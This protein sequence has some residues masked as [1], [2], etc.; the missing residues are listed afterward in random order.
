MSVFHPSDVLGQFASNVELVTNASTRSGGFTRSAYR[1]T[2]DKEPESGPDGRYFLDMVR[3]DPHLRRWG[4][5]SK[6]T[7]ST[8][9]V[10]LLY[11]RPGGGAGGGDRQSVMR[12]AADDCDKLADVCE[13]PANYGSSTSGIRIVTFQSAQ[14]V[15]QTSH[16]EIWEVLFACQWQSDL[17]TDTVAEMSQVRWIADGID[18]GTVQLISLSV[19]SL[20]TGSKVFVKSVWDSFTLDRSDTQTPDNITIVAATPAGS[21][22]WLRDNA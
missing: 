19:T 5:G 15:Q 18:T 9:S 3:V 12:N 20:E 10:R 13:N 6:I 22:N 7:D 8:I 14:R 21:G 11:A 1:F 2:L 16:G 4:D 17:D